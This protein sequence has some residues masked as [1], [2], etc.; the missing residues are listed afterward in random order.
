VLWLGLATLLLATGCGRSQEYAVARAELGRLERF[1]VTAEIVDAEPDEPL[2]LARERAR[3]RRGDDVALLVIGAHGADIDPGAKLRARWPPNLTSEIVS[4]WVQPYLSVGD[5][6][7]ARRILVRGFVLGVHQ[8]YGVRPSTPLPP[9][10]GPRADA[11][12][13]DRAVRWG[14]PLAVLAG[15]AAWRVRRRLASTSKI[16]RSGPAND[17]AVKEFR[18]DALA[19]ALLFVVPLAVYLPTLEGPFLWDDR[20]LIVEQLLEPG[21][22]TA[23]SDLFVRPFWRETAGDEPYRGFFRPLTTLTYLGDARV[24]GHNPAGFHLTNV[25]LHLMTVLAAFRLLRGF[26]AATRAS[27]L[28]AGAFALAPRLAEC[29]AWI[30]GR[31]DILAALFGVL[32]LLA[33][34]MPSRAPK[35]SGPARPLAVGADLRAILAALLLLASMLSKEVG[36]AF[37]ALVIVD[38]LQH[39]AFGRDG[40]SRRDR[41]IAAAAR[42]APVAA[43]MLVYAGLRSAALEGTPPLAYAYGGSRAGVVLEAVG[44]YARMLVDFARPRT[45][46]GFALVRDHTLVVVGAVVAAAAVIGLA[47]MLR[48]WWRR[49]EARAPVGP[50]ALLTLLAVGALLPVL[51]IAPL[52]INVVAAD[53]FLYTVLLAGT[54]A[55]AIALDRRLAG[56]SRTIASAVAGVAIVASAVALEHRTTQFLSEHAFWLDATLNAHPENPLPLNELGNVYYREQ[57][58]DTAAGLY[59]AALARYP[60]DEAY[61]AAYARTVSNVTHTLANEGHYDEALRVREW[62]SRQGRVTALDRFEVALILLH[63]GDLDG[64]ARAIDD[65]LARFRDFPEARQLARRIPELVRIR[66]R[67]ASNEADAYERASYLARIGARPEA[68]RA[69]ARLLSAGITD[70]TRRDDAAGY[71]VEFADFGLA[72]T[73]LARL[74]GLPA[75]VLARLD[76]RRRFH[77]EAVN[78]APVVRSLM[79]PLRLDEILR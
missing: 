34:P 2:E 68:S 44:T 16:A 28:A 72:E 21:R 43:A 50:A 51:H 11:N 64:A 61:R 42:L 20:T 46:I 1:G 12:D 63:R 66:D 56:A 48:P 40:R 24:H 30:S 70:A 39:A 79:R 41:A 65:A 8:L 35:Q 4:H 60:R 73:T 22:D 19:M 33:Y 75:P 32:A 69:F 77:T 7:G 23:A 58:H 53:R 57:E 6:L 67:I 5:G 71:L 38:E 10:L 59:A 9:M 45:Q 29:V 27:A 31:T 54:G 47:W 14:V 55:C 3:A 74:G 62:M 36:L 37:A 25:L 13:V 15:I 52:A 17:R 76:E 18:H 49:R 78:A 26:G